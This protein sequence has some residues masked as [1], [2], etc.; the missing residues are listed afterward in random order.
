MRL[1]MIPNLKSRPGD[2]KITYSINLYKGVLDDLTLIATA[3]GMRLPD[4]IRHCLNNL[5]DSHKTTAQQTPK[6][7]I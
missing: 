2:P 5:I 3:S 7:T 4:V 6:T 1:V